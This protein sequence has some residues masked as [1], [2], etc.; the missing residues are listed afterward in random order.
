VGDR[1]EASIEGILLTEYATRRQKLMALLPANS[2]A[3]IPAA[4]TIYM[5]NDIPYVSTCCACV[6]TYLD[7]AVHSLSRSDPPIC[8]VVIT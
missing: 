5:S 7:T 2:V 1:G 8:S 3:V 6:D 4:P